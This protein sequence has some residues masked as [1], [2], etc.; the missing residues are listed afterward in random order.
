MNIL[1]IVQARHDS[2]RLPGKVLKKINDKT[3]IEI[4]LNNLKKL[5]FVDKIVVST[6]KNK[7]NDNLANHIK[8]T[9]FEVFRGAEDD[10]LDRFYKTAKKY[11]AKNVIRI[12][13][14]CPLIDIKIL[15]QVV[16]LFFKKKVDY[17]SNTSPPTW[18]DGLDVE[19]F[20]FSI[21]E[22]AWKNAT[23]QYDREHVTSYMRNNLEISQ[24][25]YFNVT[26]ASD[27]RWT[28]DEE[29][30]LKVISKII[31]NFGPKY[32]FSFENIMD[33]KRK[34]PNYFM[35]NKSIK[36]NEG[37]TIGNGQKIWKRAKKSILGGNM[38]LSK[39]PDL[40]LP[41]FWPSYYKKSS[42]ISVWSLDDQEY[43]DM[44]FAVG[45]N[46]LGYANQD[47]ENA[48]IDAIKSGNMTTLNS[49]E[50]VYL[51]EKLID[52]HPW[53]EVVKFARSGGEANAMAIRIAR[54]SSKNHKVAV[55]GYHG[56][57]DWYLAANLSDN[58]ELNDHLM[59]GLDPLG[60]PDNL[61]NTIYTF[62]YNDFDQFEKLVR[63]YEIG[64][65]KMEV[66]RNHE[67][68]NN[69]LQK[70]R[71][72]CDKKNII[73]IFDECTSGFRETNGGIHKKYDVIP[74]IAMFGKAIGNGHAITAVIGKKSVMENA[75]SS[76]ISSTFWTE[77]IGPVAALK[78]LEVMEKLKSWEIISKTGQL[79]KDGWRKIAANNKVPIQISGIDAICSFT[80]THKDFLGFKTYMTQEMLKRGFLASTLFYPSTCHDEK[81]INEYFENLDEIFKVIGK[82]I[83]EESNIV[84]FLNGPAS[85]STF[86]RL[87]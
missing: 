49:P 38:L 79:M 21:L 28:V 63:D 23:T 48:V 12:T 13:A 18:P 43:K 22:K 87:N 1:L 81:S 46:T 52:L 76:F 86:K 10:V 47:I 56:W 24:E 26:D 82:I 51:S 65:V 6:S 36:R 84:D 15:D 74:D 31:K 69:F 33:F 25:N 14:D 77:R 66:I 16:K 59:P 54:S 3:I 7:S 73:L 42:G 75:K 71:K 35:A 19:I 55:C 60:V 34:N 62:N 78:T 4:L 83:N 37:A 5:D 9:G 67:P 50:E 57:H 72:V 64:I 40:F 17:C 58:N 85:G 39:N 45:Q 2:K 70:I 8:D 27:E 29:D 80:I 53:S 30:D 44:I 32:D 20:K 41:E 61:K 68:K 11:S